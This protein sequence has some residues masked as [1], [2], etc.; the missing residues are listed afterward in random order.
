MKNIHLPYASETSS[1]NHSPGRDN[2][3]DMTTFDKRTSLETSL[4]PMFP[5][6]PF[7]EEEQK[8]QS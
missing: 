7:K 4:Y 1:P 2:H 5:P 8:K 6:S 3:S